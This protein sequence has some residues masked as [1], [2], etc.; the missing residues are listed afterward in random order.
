LSSN[1]EDP[2]LRK[3]N[4]KLV[5]TK[6]EFRKLKLA[7]ERILKKLDR[8][9]QKRDEENPTIFLTHNIPYRTKLD[10]LLDK[11]S[12]YYR[13]HFGSSVARWF[14]DKYQPLVCIGGHMHEHFGKI[15][16]RKTLVINVGFGAHVNVMIELE[17][18]RVKEVLFWDGKGR[19]RIKK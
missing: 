7:Y 3:K 4:V 14:C 2:F 13:K 19:Y 18:E 17:G 8:A 9:Y 10:T 12:K 6:E 1:T 5:Y 16:T 15:R 11:K